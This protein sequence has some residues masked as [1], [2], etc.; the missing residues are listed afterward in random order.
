MII[1]SI[2]IIVIFVVIICYFKKRKSTY[3]GANEMEDSSI[4]AR[5]TETLDASNKTSKKK[6]S[7]EKTGGINESVDTIE[8]DGS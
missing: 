8:I 3:T 6:R 1:A 2:I 7:G 5:M 4:N